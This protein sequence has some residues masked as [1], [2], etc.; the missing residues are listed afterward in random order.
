M[1]FSV[2]E[3]L[4]DIKYNID[5]GGR[6]KG[7][8]GE[9]DRSVHYEKKRGILQKCVN[10]FVPHCSWFN[11]G[12]FG[13]WELGSYCLV[14]TQ[15]NHCIVPFARMTSYQSNLFWFSC[16]QTWDMHY[17]YGQAAEAQ[18]SSYYCSTQRHTGVDNYRHCC[19]SGLKYPYYWGGKDGKVSTPSSQN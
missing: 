14:F 9:G 3:R 5:F 10:T 4:D 11:K 2:E 17:F 8:R 6:G 7:D 16:I 19:A 13:H 15:V 12:C 18:S 1:L